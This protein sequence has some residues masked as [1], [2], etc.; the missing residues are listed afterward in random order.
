MSILAQIILGIDPG[1]RKAGFGVLQYSQGRLSY[2]AS[3]CIRPKSHQ[4]GQRLCELHEHIQ[5]IIQTYKPDL[6]GM[7]EVFMG[8]NWR[9]ALTLGQARGVLWL[10]CEQYGVAPQ[11]IAARLVKKSITGYGAAKK[12]QV[13]AMVMSLLGLKQAPQEDAA[14]ALAIA[15]AISH[16]LKYASLG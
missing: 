4:V 3:G 14:D 16:S 15:I 13:T 11:A 7:E 5:T 9:S 10:A 6:I 2:I 12:E 8:A 1:S